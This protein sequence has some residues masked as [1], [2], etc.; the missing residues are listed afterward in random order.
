MKNFNK[1]TFSG[2]ENRKCTYKTKSLGKDYRMKEKVLLII[3]KNHKTPQ[4]PLK[5]V[6]ELYVEN[7]NI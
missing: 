4:I 3:I 2:T 1:N 7:Y 6:Q 5:N